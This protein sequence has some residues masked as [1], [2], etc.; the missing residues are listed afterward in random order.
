MN[1]EPVSAEFI[2]DALAGTPALFKL[3]KAVHHG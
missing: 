1:G 2:G 3:T